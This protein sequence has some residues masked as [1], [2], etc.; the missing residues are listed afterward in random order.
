MDTV[1]KGPLAAVDE[2]AQTTGANTPIRTK[3]LEP[4]RNTTHLLKKLFFTALAIVALLGGVLAYHIYQVT[5][6]PAGH[7]A[8]VQLARMDLGMPIDE[9]GA[10]E[11][12]RT[13]LQMEGVKHCYVNAD[14]GIITYGYDRA[15]QTQEHVV[16]HVRS[17]TSIPVERFVASADDLSNGCPIKPRSMMTFW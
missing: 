15:A 8:N 1:V 11:L 12:K 10:L 14:A 4:M 3:N 6:K 5:R 16:E 7:L 9:E 13:V 2:A 17:T